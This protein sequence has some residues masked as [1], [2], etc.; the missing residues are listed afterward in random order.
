MEGRTIRGGLYNRQNQWVGELKSGLDS[1][2]NIQ[3]NHFNV[4][5]LY[6]GVQTKGD[7]LF[8]FSLSL[9]LSLWGKMILFFLFSRIVRNNR[10]GW[11]NMCWL[12]DRWAIHTKNLGRLFCG[13]VPLFWSILFGHQL[14][15]S[16][17]LL[18]FFCYQV[19]Q[20]D[21]SGITQGKCYRCSLD[22]FS[23]PKTFSVLFCFLTWLSLLCLCREKSSPPPLSIHSC[24]Y[25][26]TRVSLL[27]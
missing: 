20:Y 14:T 10:V 4:F 8:N 1:S 15:S 13:G 9:S 22:L 23:S 17:A 18:L 27:D 7:C 3:T 2:W 25:C 12:G 6:K 11:K 19:E 24:C 21:E 16:G 26:S 5:Y